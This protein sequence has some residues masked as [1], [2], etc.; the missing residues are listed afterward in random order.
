[1]KRLTNIVVNLI[2]IAII[3]SGVLLIFNQ[4]IQEHFISEASGDLLDMDAD[5][6]AENHN[7]DASYNFDDIEELTLT[8]I[9]SLQ[10]TK[11]YVPVIA[12][13]AI[14]SVNIR[15]PIAKGLSE[16]ALAT[17]A[18][19]M[20]ESQQLGE[21]NYTLAS[22]N[23]EGTDV[24][25]SPLHRLEI[26]ELIYITDLQDIYTYE[27]TIS[28]VVEPT[29]VY[30]LDDVP[31]KRLLTLITCAFDGADRL[32]IQATFKDKTPLDKATQEMLNAFDR[33]QT[34]TQWK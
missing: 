28:E 12:Q 27:V 33:L 15:L 24:L 5:T 3:F 25:F 13:I 10:S 31:N 8:D 17:G 21:G 20:K 1:M 23:L 4:P 7:A 18:G 30:V 16:T 22:H 29:A 11:S 14:P 32:H 2:L 6:I 9:L 34:H 19:T 26:G